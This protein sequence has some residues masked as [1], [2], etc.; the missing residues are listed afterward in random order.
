MYL[1]AEA[2]YV[3][4]LPPAMSST[5]NIAHPT[6]PNRIISDVMHHQLS[7]H[8]TRDDGPDSLN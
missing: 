3:S 2:S 1:V 5:Y 6:T 7:S 8:H 4:L